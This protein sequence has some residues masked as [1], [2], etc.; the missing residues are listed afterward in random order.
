VV[1]LRAD[2]GRIP[3]GR[4][5]VHC[6]VTS[7]PYFGLRRYEGV[8]E[9][10]W[11]GDPAHGHEWGEALPPIKAGQV[12][13]TKWKDAPA[14]AEG[15]R[16]NTGACCLCGAWRGCLGNEP[17]VALYVE[18]MVAVFREVRRVL[19]DDGVCWLNL[20]DSYSGGGNGGGG[21]FA[22]DGPRMM[23]EGDKNVRTRPAHTPG[24][25]A[26]N[27]LGVPWRVAFALQADGWLLRNDMIW[28]KKAPMPESVAGWR[29]QRCR[30][31]TAGGSRSER[32]ALARSAQQDHDG[33]GFAPSAEWSDCPG[34]D[35]CA[36]TAGLVLR[37]GSWRH[38]R[39]HEYVFMLAKTDCYFADGEAAKEVASPASA[40]RYKYN[41]SGAPDGRHDPGGHERICPEGERESDGKRNPR[42]FMLLGPEPLH[43]AHFAAMPTEIPR[44]LIAAS[45]PT[46]GVCRACGSP[47]A[48]VAPPTSHAG[49]RPTCTCPSATPVPATILDPFAGSGTTG[50]VAAELGRRA[51]LCDL[52]G[53]YL[54]DIAGRRVGAAALAGQTSTSGAA[55]QEE[56]F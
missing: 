6:V 31:K 27:L 44:R 33:H 51:I 11:G 49:W 35:K 20:G 42:S 46:R 13:Q 47:W 10:V 34:C 50:V 56:M 2:A 21:S 1:R 16:A 14:V 7:P 40:D 30:T 36:A 32:P 37:R 5:R 12:A 8:P 29:W 48:R 24:F 4:G 28:G 15:Q 3:L 38:T 53:T 23:A 55:T 41:F 45:T 26:G 9:T 19:R 43:E 54:R 22:Q 18:H 17:T 39:A 52:S 25:P